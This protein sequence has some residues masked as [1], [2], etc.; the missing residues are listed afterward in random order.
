[1]ADDG[2]TGRE[3]WKSDGTAA[4]T[5]LVKDIFPGAGE[6]SPPLFAVDGTLYFPANDGTHGTEVWKSDG[7]AAGAVRLADLNPR[8]GGAASLNDVVKLG[9]GVLLV[10]SD[11][12]RGY[13]LWRSDGTAAG[14]GSS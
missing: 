10:V 4:G 5:V 2:T 8:T 14:H 12:T 11:G 9:S 7:T 13:E 6:R 3:L 1:M